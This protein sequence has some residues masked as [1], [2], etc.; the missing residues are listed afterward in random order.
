M[1]LCYSAFKRKRCQA[2]PAEIW[3][4]TS[5][6]AS[7]LKLDHLTKQLMWGQPIWC[8]SH[9]Q[10]PMKG[11]GFVMEDSHSLLSASQKWIILEEQEMDPG[12]LSAAELFCSGW[13]PAACCAATLFLSWASSDKLNSSDN[14]ERSGSSTRR[15]PSDSHLL[16]EPGESCRVLWGW[17][18]QCLALLWHEI[19][20]PPFLLRLKWEL[21]CVPDL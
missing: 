2:D 19:S 6:E 11:C 8:V 10:H 9:H 13:Q 3:T 12:L 7:Y 5:T 4:R 16:S 15:W 20:T 18:W 14:G 21:G 1:M 17:K